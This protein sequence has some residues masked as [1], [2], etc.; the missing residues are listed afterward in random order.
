MKVTDVTPPT[1]QRAGFLRRWLSRRTEGQPGPVEDVRRADVVRVRR[2]P[3]RRARERRLGDATR[4]VHVSAAPFIGLLP[5]EFVQAFRDPTAEDRTAVLRAPHHVG[6]EVV[7]A[8][9]E[10]ANLP[11]PGHASITHVSLV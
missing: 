8:A 10:P 2:E 4:P 11:G 3:A 5:D 7:P 1:R 9:G 6:H